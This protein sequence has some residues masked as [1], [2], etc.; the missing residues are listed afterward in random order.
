MEEKGEEAVPRHEDEASFLTNRPPHAPVDVLQQE[1]A[2]TT[3][4]D[5][6]NDQ[7]GQEKLVDTFPDNFFNGIE[8]TKQK[9][10]EPWTPPPR[11]SGPPPMGMFLQEE[12]TW[13]IFN[14]AN[15]QPTNVATE[16]QPRTSGPPPVGM[17]LKERGE[18]SS[19]D[20]LSPW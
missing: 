1:S 3:N 6:P 12:K 18:K 8:S 16:P 20:G 17:F 19:F 13:G 11:R 2:V 14:V 5:A 10:D 15:E 4:T 9:E 7:Q